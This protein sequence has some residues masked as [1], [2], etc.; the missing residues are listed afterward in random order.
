MAL[1]GLPGPG[2]ST[3]Q[4]IGPGPGTKVLVAQG[5]DTPALHRNQSIDLKVPIACCKLTCCKYKGLP[6]R[7]GYALA[8]L[9]LAIYSNLPT[10]MPNLQTSRQTL[11]RLGISLALERWQHVPLHLDRSLSSATSSLPLYPA[12]TRQNRANRSPLAAGQQSFGWQPLWMPSFCWST[13]ELRNR[14]ATPLHPIIQLVTPLDEFIRLTTT[15]SQ[16]VARPMH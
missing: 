14:L 15:W 3:D 7:W 10:A 4:L 6:A 9:F 1:L 2:E 5:A 12:A 11:H 8:P 16:S 13:L